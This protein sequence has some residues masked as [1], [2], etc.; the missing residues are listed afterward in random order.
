[1]LQCDFSVV[2][3][4]KILKLEIAQKENL[5]QFSLQCLETKSKPGMAQKNFWDSF[6]LFFHGNQGQK[7][8]KKRLG[9][10]CCNFWGAA[11]A[12]DG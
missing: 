7:W 6:P 12:R 4:A 9:I 3:L 5:G 2:F 8:V 1:M 10:V 11:K